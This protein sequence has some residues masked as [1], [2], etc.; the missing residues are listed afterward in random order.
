MG[1][2]W[3]FFVRAFHKQLKTQQQ[4]DAKHLK[5]PVIVFYLA[6]SYYTPMQARVQCIY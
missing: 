3:Q 1:P 2:P 4:V 5:S 6:S